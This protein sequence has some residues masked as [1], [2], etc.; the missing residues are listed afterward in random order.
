M[1]GK[2]GSCHEFIAAEIASAG[3][4]P[5]ARFMELALY[6]KEHGYYAS[7][8]PRVGRSG[9]FFTGVSVGPALGLV[10]SR[11]VLAAWK[12][13]GH[14]S[15]FCIVE[16]G[17]NDGSLAGDLLGALAA[18]DL[19][20]C[21]HYHIIEPLP[22]WRSRQQAVLGGDS[23]VKWFDSLEN[24]PRFH[25]IHIS[26]ELVDALPFHI[27]SAVENGWQELL[28][29]AWE[30]G[31]RF[32]GG[33]PSDA[34]RDMVAKLPP[35]PP[36]YLTELRPSVSE[37]IASVAERLLSGYV[38]VIDYGMESDRLLDLSRSRG[39]FRAYQGHHCDENV[40]AEPGC[41][42]L[43]AH[44]D[45]TELAAAACRVGLREDG[46]TDQHHF[47]I[48]TLA[49]WLREREGHHP[50]RLLRGIKMLMHPSTMGLQ[51]HVM[52]MRTSD[53]PGGALPGFS[54]APGLVP[55]STIG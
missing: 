2:A 16:Q 12:A 40:L 14:P 36:G 25:G 45:F 48:R 15:D 33:P 35:R 50:D 10:L 27:V 41:R 13:M 31:F 39:T 54:Q 22:A 23:R 53:V 18:T 37:W 5:F 38:L 6:S 34:V 11:H 1:R 49:G 43:T 21:V 30:G 24:S 26:N 7:G 20:D 32:L 3:P 52:G 51:F 44:V 19:G 55:T 47:V 46:W 4:I 28:V 29:E 42:D 17:A 9:D 8:I